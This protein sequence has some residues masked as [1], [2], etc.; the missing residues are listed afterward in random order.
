VRVDIITTEGE[1]E[2]MKNLQRKATAADKM[3]ADLVA[4][5]NDSIRIDSRHNFNQSERMPAW[6]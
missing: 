3:F 1:Q 6:L 2:V 4:F 5:M